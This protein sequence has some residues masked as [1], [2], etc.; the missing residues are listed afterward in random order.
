[1]TDPIGRATVEIKGDASH[2]NRTVKEAEQTTHK[3]G[4]AADKS[5]KKFSKS[6]EDT[7]NRATRL[8]EVLS[9]LFIPALFVGAVLRAT[10][11]IIDM[12]GA[13]DRLRKSMDDAFSQAERKANQ[14]RRSGLTDLAQTLADLNDQQREATNNILK[15]FEEGADPTKF[16]GLVQTLIRGSEDAEKS[17]AR[18]QSVF[19]ELRRNAIEENRKAQQRANREM[20]I[21]TAAIMDQVLEMQAA[22]L[23]AEG[24]I[25]DAVEL[26]R[27]IEQSAHAANLAEIAEA[28]K[29]YDRAFGGSDNFRFEAM[30]S[31][32]TSLHQMRVKLLEDEAKKG[33]AAYEKEMEDAIR[34]IQERM[35]SSFGFDFTGVD[36]VAAAID[37]QTAA[38]DRNR[39]F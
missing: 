20:S 27:Q 38:I 11:A 26:R 15:V 32:V 19:A 29:A 33:A 5:G 1:M 31:A 39:R 17:I 14:L 7:A 2:L 30:R 13:G 36:Q 24:R 4:D 25:A 21:E 12:A 22:R 8:Q 28:E 3:V 16:S 37:R 35:R 18:A 9:K 34:R 23:E 10:K 6:F